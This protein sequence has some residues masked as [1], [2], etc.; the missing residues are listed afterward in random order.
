MWVGARKGA[1]LSGL[2][3][4]RISSSVSD[5]L[6][7]F[8]YCFC[9]IQKG[10][11]FNETYSIAC[12]LFDTMDPALG[13]DVVLDDRIDMSIGHRL[14][15]AKLQGYPLALCLGKQVS[16]FLQPLNQV[17]KI[18]PGYCMMERNFRTNLLRDYVHY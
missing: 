8:V 6:I 13:G 5:G 15:E 4:L 14:R 10:H 11:R 3:L 9:F 18:L 12:D 17:D 7:L 1:D 16:R 2:S